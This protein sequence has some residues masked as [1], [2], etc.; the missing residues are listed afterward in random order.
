MRSGEV[1]E[2]PCI[3]IHMLQVNVSRIPQMAL[4]YGVASKTG[5]YQRGG[6]EGRGCFFSFLFFLLFFYICST[7]K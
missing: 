1:R 3:S 6:A 4:S 7:V 5:M 2:K